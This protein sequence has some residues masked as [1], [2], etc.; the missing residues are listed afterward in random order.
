MKR[1]F[2]EG[3]DKSYTGTLSLLHFAFLSVG[4]LNK[5]EIRK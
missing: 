4:I 5:K 2:L 1:N 3:K